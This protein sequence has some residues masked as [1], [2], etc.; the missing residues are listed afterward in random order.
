MVLVLVIGDF[1]IP[2]RASDI[3]K[4][5]QELL[6]P[7][8]I[9]TILCTGNL[10]C[11]EPHDYLKKLASDI[12]IVQGD[13]DENTDFPETKVVTIGEFK[14]GLCHGHQI[15]PWGDEES[16]GVLQRKLNCDV[17]ISGHTHQLDVRKFD[18]KFLINPGSA[19]GAYSGFTSD[20][21]PSFVLLDIQNDTVQAFV[22]QLVDEQLDIE[23]IVFKKVPDEEEG[24]EG[25]A[26]EEEEEEEE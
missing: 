9:D 24:E 11:K 23:R 21:P 14:F 22:Y 26:E 5:F 4:Q 12:H 15:T 1:H 19:T 20:A 10:C 18:E 25:D 6:V 16:L 13:F 3:P 8:K 17:L 7:D 2:H